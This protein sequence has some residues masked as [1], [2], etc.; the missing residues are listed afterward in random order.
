MAWQ[1]AVLFWCSFPVSLHIFHHHQMAVIDFVCFSGLC[2]V[3][4]IRFRT[5]STQGGRNSSLR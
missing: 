2:L 3:V 4:S 1:E 5:C